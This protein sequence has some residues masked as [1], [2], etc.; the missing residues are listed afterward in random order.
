MKAYWGSG[1]IAPRYL[2]LGIRW[3][4]VVSFTMRSLY[5]RGKSPWIGGWVGPREDMDTVVKR[6]YPIIVPPGN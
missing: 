5:S 4:R 1:C 2:N 6:N 3:K